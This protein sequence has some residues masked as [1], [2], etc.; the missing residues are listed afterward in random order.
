M[1]I[2]KL[3]RL[4]EAFGF[5]RGQDNSGGSFKRLNLQRFQRSHDDRIEGCQQ[6]LRHFPTDGLQFRRVGLV[7]QNEPACLR[8]DVLQSAGGVGED[9][10]QGFWCDDFTNGQAAQPGEDL[11]SMDESLR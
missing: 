7:Q 3:F 10:Q 8:W 9:T 4:A 5:A 2:Q 6:I 1:V 11:R